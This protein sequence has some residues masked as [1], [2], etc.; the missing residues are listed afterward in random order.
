MSSRAVV[1]YR[2]TARIMMGEKKNRRGI[3]LLGALMIVAAIAVVFMSWA[4]FLL[5]ADR[6]VSS[7]VDAAIVLQG[8]TA[9]EKVRVAGAMDL[10]RQGIAEQVLLS[11]PPRLNWDEPARPAAYAYLQRNYGQQAAQRVLFCEVEPTI[12]S[13][14]DE[15]DAL[16]DC[17]RAFG[18]KSIVVVT[19]NYHTRRAQIL[20]RR[21]LRRRNSSINLSIFGAPDPDFQ[22]SG[23]WRKRLYAK[24][25]LLEFTKLVWEF[26]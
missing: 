19:S 21:M 2:A 8:S 3:W 16:Y 4:R 12:N 18:W 6:Q 13:T 24:T 5:V 22:A 7:H 26:F 1:L 25:W 23:W 9:G 10:L 11:I 15:A 14:E 20:W 17:I